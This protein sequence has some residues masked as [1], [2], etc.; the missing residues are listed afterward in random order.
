MRKC[1]LISHSNRGEASLIEL[2]KFNRSET[3]TLT[4]YQV[5][6]TG[7][8]SRPFSA[9]A[10]D[11]QTGIRPRSADVLRAVG[12]RNTLPLSIKHRRHYLIA[13]YRIAFREG[14]LKAR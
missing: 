5:W 1:L 8:R 11:T 6:Q 13:F 10:G 7:K 9:R 14:S 12:E 2:K 4:R 3:S